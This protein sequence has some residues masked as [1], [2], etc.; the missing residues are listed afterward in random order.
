MAKTGKKGK[1]K[2]QDSNILEEL[3]EDEKE[4]VVIT[5]EKIFDLQTKDSNGI[6]SFINSLPFFGNEI[7]LVKHR[8]NREQYPAGKAQE[9]QIKIDANKYTKLIESKLK[10][11]PKLYKKI[12]NFQKERKISNEGENLE[13]KEIYNDEE[14]KMEENKNIGLK[15][16]IEI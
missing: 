8:P 9:P 4:E 2:S 5:K 7:S 1:L 15:I 3:S 16:L 10:E 14:I 12:K 6:K 13:V 11:N